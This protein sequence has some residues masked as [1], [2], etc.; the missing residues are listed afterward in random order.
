MKKII[1]LLTITCLWA[2]SKAQT[3]TSHIDFTQYAGKTGTYCD[4]VYSFKKVNDT[5][6]LVDMGGYYPNQN[7]T[8]AV[9]GN[10]ITINWAGLKKKHICVT[11]TVILFKQKP[12]IVVYDPET[13]KFN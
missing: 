2:T 12:E 11:G 8:L 10:K 6:T 3:R 4:T 7:F 13:L 9:K 1:L 5:L